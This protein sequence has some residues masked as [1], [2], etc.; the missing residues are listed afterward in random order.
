MDYLVANSI[1]LL[2]TGFVLF[3]SLVS[4]L[5]WRRRESPAMWIGTAVWAFLVAL[6]A[7]ATVLLSQASATSPGFATLFTVRQFSFGFGLLA[8]VWVLQ[9]IS[10][11]WSRVLTAALVILNVIRAAF[12]ATTD[13]FWLGTTT[14]DGIPQ[15]GPARDWFLL[16]QV[17]IAFA[18]VGF[19]LSRPWRYAT[20]RRAAIW[21]LIPAGV[22]FGF[23]TVLPWR[24]QNYVTVAILSIPVLIIQA[25]LLGRMASQYRTVEVSRQRE[26][27]LAEFGRQALTPGGVVPAQAAVA[28]VMDV[29]EPT[30][31]EFI[32][33]IRG[34][35]RPVATAGDRPTSVDVVGVTVPVESAGQLFGELS[36]FGEVEPN[37]SVFLRGV[38]LI[39]SAALSRA[40]QE[41]EL[42]DQALR[43]GVTGLPNWILLQ[44]R[45]GG[46]LT[47]RGDRRLIVLCCDIKELK[48]I[49]DDFGHETG[50]AAL[51][52]VG[53]RLVE[54]AEL[55]GTVA[56]IG[57]GE[58]IVARLV[59]S[60]QAAE[61][62]SHR[63]EMIGDEIL[64]ISG[65]SVPCELYVGFVTTED[66][67]AEPD[68]LVREAE[69][70][71][72]QAKASSAKRALYNSSEREARDGRR[73]MSRA[74]AAAIQADQ[75]HVEYQ[76]IVELASQRIVGV[77][78]LARWR[79]PDG[80]NVPP[81]VFIP[82]A[83][84]D[85]MITALS[86]RVFGQALVQLG[87]WDRLGLRADGLR[88]SLNVTPNVVG[89]ADF[90]SWLTT[91]LDSHDI[92]PSRITLE[93]TESALERAEADVLSHLSW[94]SAL[95]PRVSLDDFGTGYSSLSRLLTLPVGELKID[96]SFTMTGP[97]PHREIVQTVVDLAH[98][99]DLAVVAEGI[100][101]HEQWSMLL[102][103]GCDYGQGYLFSRPLPGE[104]IPEF[105]SRSR[106]HLVD[107]LDR[108]RLSGG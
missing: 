59:D 64:A 106:L 75:I 95:G 43:D 84:A 12:W 62:F 22:L 82:I 73:R 80:V 51:R 8:M 32:E 30:Y 49:N 7:V 76:P 63:A 29:L 37:D 47:R 16:A 60:P 89:D 6:S 17:L 1:M 20:A 39:L 105:I 18:I 93:L 15:F 56:R 72:M 34:D 67:G 79:R 48:V 4:I 35:R 66:A 52:E 86:E 23:I 26:A 85:G 53:A 96:R 40:Q 44:D 97:G 108:E 19:V 55:G 61:Q 45:I 78:A 104:R 88:L 41:V 69:I 58:F 31:C 83:E 57:G 50:D 11:N 107:D 92:D 13:L 65:N 21:A 9:A 3:P 101:T 38:G 81:G 14:A 68:R 25:V 27:R 33:L 77:E 46:L 102:A 99:S 94:V 54:I 10:G 103:D 2:L 24:A 28:L 100:E 36:I 98:R 71:M 42:R 70:A 5:V 87:M 74:L 91:I 90:I